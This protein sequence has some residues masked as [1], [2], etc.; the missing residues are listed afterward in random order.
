MFRWIRR[1]HLHLYAGYV[2]ARR[3]V[4][5]EPETLMVAFHVIASRK[6]EAY[7]CGKDWLAGHCPI[8]HGWYQQEVGLLHVSPLMLRLRAFAACDGMMTSGHVRVTD[9]LPKEQGE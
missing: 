4:G 6:S 7:Q 3:F 9:D 8:Q 5:G 1:R 2:S